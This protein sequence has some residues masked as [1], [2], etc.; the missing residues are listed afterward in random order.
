MYPNKSV[1]TVILPGKLQNNP[2]SHHQSLIID[3]RLVII[4]LGVLFVLVACDLY[5]ANLRRRIGS[6]KKTLTFV[7]LLDLEVL[8]QIFPTLPLATLSPLQSRSHT[9][10]SPNSQTSSRCT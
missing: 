4:L 8:C 2:D 3:Q 7:S 5:L 1:F 6:T 9:R 10:N